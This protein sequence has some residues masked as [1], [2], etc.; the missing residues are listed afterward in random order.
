MRRCDQGSHELTSTEKKN[1]QNYTNLIKTET[2]GSNYHATDFSLFP[3]IQ[4]F[5]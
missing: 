5:T 3:E 2:G 4:I 1:K